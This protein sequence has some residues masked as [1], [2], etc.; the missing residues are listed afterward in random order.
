MLELFAEVSLAQA[1]P[2]EGQLLAALTAQV[3]EAVGSRTRRLVPP[4]GRYLR[5]QRRFGGWPAVQAPEMNYCPYQVGALVGASRTRG[6]LLEPVRMHFAAVC[7]LHRR[8]AAGGVGVKQGAKFGEQVG[9]CQMLIVLHGPDLGPGCE[10]PD[11][12]VR[13]ATEAGQA[14]LCRP[15]EYLA[16][17]AAL[18]GLDCAER[19]PGDERSPL[20]TKRERSL[21]GQFPALSEIGVSVH[22]GLP[23][24]SARDRYR[25][26]GSA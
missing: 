10:I 8:V 11:D 2:H 7:Q 20:G 26:R 12:P 1:A 14:S 4:T 16:A 19:A 15:L 5:F 23:L 3:L 22:P 21:Q 6:P 24:P 17:G 18:P 9:D 13:P 25:H